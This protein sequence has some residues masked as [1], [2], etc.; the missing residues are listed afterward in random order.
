M[1][2]VN[3]VF[4]YQVCNEADLPLPTNNLTQLILD[5]INP[6][7]GV[8]EYQGVTGVAWE[9]ATYHK[10]RTLGALPS[11]PVYQYLYFDMNTL[12][13]RFVEIEGIIFY[14]EKGFVAKTFTEHDLF[15]KPCT[16]PAIDYIAQF[17]G[18]K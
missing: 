8:F 13:L 6:Q 1:H 7:S 9:N 2:A 14:S 11:G 15:V 10:F 18:Q 4:E 12:N 5:V 3:R 17:F 16:E